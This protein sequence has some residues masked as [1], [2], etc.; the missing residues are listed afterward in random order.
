MSA[1]FTSADELEKYGRLW[2]SWLAV[3]KPSRDWFA[4]WCVTCPEV[5][6]E[7]KIAEY[8]KSLG[9]N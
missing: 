3:R 5:P 7:K 1:M 9:V 4:W 6:D 8:E 2:D